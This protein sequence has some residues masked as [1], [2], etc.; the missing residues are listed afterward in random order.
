M[1]FEGLTRPKIKWK[2][3]RETPC[4]LDPTFSRCVWKLWVWLTRL[5]CCP[6]AANG[7][8]PHWTCPA[9]YIRAT[10]T[11]S[12][13]PPAVYKHSLVHFDNCEPR[14]RELSYTVPKWINF[15]RPLTVLEKTWSCGW[16]PPAGTV[17]HCS[18]VYPLSAVGCYYIS[19]EVHK[20]RGFKFIKQATVADWPLLGDEYCISKNQDSKMQ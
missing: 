5:S 1:H 4:I 13:T 17:S 10:P 18:P 6:A 12:S 20:N 14:E 11:C 7:G 15:W 8:P 19:S 3:I 9:S 2:K 16:T